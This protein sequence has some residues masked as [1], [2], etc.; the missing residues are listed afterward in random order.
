MIT[1]KTH[2]RHENAPGTVTVQRFETERWKGI[3]FCHPKQPSIWEVF[4]LS[5]W[6]KRNEYIHCQS[7]ARQE[8]NQR[9]KDV[10]D[11]SPLG[12][13]STELKQK[14]KGKSAWL[15]QSIEFCLPWHRKGWGRVTDECR[16]RNRR[17]CKV[18]LFALPHL[19]LSFVR[20]KNTCH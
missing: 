13:L 3:S 19:C 20:M 1:K 11:P 12:L 18:L 15:M 4:S 5:M 9:N 7:P 2:K 16:K 10:L 17:A 14:A 8:G 6:L